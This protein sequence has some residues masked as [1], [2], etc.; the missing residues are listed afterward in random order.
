MSQYEKFFKA[1]CQL[2]RDFSKPRKK[3]EVLQEVVDKTVES[4]GVKAASLFLADPH[5]EI[6]VKMASKGLSD[7]Y[8]HA[9]PMKVKKNLA[10]IERDGY[11]FS[12]DVTADER[13]DNVEAK[14]KEGIASLLS[15][16]IYIRGEFSGVLTL[17]TSDKREFL[18]EEIEF[19]KA[20]AERGGMA[21]ERAR[22]IENLLNNINCFMDLTAKM[23]EDLDIKS[24]LGNL[25]GDV[26]K[27]F[28][29]KGAIIRLF[30]EA[31]G[32]WP[33]VASHGVSD[34]YLGKGPLT[35][36]GL[37]GRI[38]KGEIV[39]IEDAGDHPD[40]PY[41]EAQRE[42][43]VVSVMAVPIPLK[44]KIIGVMIILCGQRHWF[45]KHEVALAEALAQQGGLAIQNSNLVLMLKQDIE[46]MKEDMYSMKSWF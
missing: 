3:E 24:I 11:L 25:T 21:I 29:V 1:L 32:Q 2:S 20:V 13:L 44:K 6:F 12:Y 10:S 33:A 9:G 18:P 43:G 19:V 27:A 16:P 28:N 34:N 35:S 31:S 38:L 8:F 17:Y 46:L 45:Q 23:N 15:V 37:L 39:M 14:V 40:V 7:S 26:A 5:E 42:E 30:D 41:Q 36:E 4:M 22:L